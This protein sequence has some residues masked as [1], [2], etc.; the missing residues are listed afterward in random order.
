LSWRSRI[1]RRAERLARI[2]GDFH[3]FNVLFDDASNLS[4]LDTSRGSLGDPADDVT[5][6]SINFP[7]FALG[8]PGAWRGAF[9]SFWYEFWRDYVMLTRDE[10]VFEVAAPFFAWRGLVL[11]N[12]RWYPDLAPRDRDRILGFVESVL[13]LERFSPA[14]AEEFFDS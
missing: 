2:H 7:F 9:R 8:H 5:S 1:K 11:A 4:V 6:M 14:L 10:G 3:P 13:A 12:P